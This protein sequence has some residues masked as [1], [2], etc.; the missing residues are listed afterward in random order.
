M[1]NEIRLDN[2]V[3]I[4]TGA[5][6]GL[7]RSHALAMAARGAKVVVNDL[8]GRMDGTGAARS[9][10]D[11]VVD[12]IRA[13]GGEAVANYDSVATPEGGRAIVQAAV[14]AFGTVDIVVNNAGIILYK[15][16]MDH[17]PEDFASNLAVHLSGSFYV[18]QAAFPIMKEKR[19]GRLVFTSSSGGLR[20]GADVVAYGA[21]KAGVMG[22]AFVMALT[23]APYNIFSNVILPNAYTRMT[24]GVVA[25]RNMEKLSPGFI[26]PI[27]VYLSSER[28][29]LNH[30]M[31]ACGAGTVARTIIAL[32]QGW[33][34]ES[35]AELT[36][37]AIHDHLAEIM[38]M[39]NYANPQNSEEETRLVAGRRR[40]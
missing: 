29:T 7:G 34:A 25:E 11:G 19:Y 37:E 17:T 8:G 16:F 14:D 9:A 23:G 10:A 28:C 5:G 21:A 3:A 36:P 38:D 32:A 30:E 27:V 13:A 18:S 24:E 2:R 22:L 40:K 20:G 26:S 15:R 35:K 33:R 12:E 39:T 4:I 31:F 1:A 6:A